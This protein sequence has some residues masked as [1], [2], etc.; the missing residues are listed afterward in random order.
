MLGGRRLTIVITV[1]VLMAA[2]TSV[3]G[4]GD[5]RAREAYSRAIGLETQGNNQ[6]ALSLLWEAAGLAPRDADIQNR[7]GEAL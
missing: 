5:T 3:S 1:G 6:A 7:L 2:V 4:Q